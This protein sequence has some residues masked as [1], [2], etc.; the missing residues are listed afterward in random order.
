MTYKVVLTGEK[1]KAIFAIE[2][3][4]AE[5]AIHAVRDISLYSHDAVKVGSVEVLEGEA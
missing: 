1:W 5:A 4:D 2:A 3:Q